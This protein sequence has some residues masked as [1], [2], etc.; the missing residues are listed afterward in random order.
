M[1]PILNETQKPRNQLQETLQEKEGGS[2]SLPQEGKVQGETPKSM[3]I[4]YKDKE[5]W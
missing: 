1:F 5:G 2:F 3:I 4:K